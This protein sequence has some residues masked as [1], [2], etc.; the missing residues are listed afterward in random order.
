MNGDFTTP[1]LKDVLL[2]CSNLTIMSFVILTGLKIFVDNMASL[3][4]V[5][6]WAFIMKEGLDVFAQRF[7]R[8]GFRAS[9]ENV[10]DYDASNDFYKVCLLVFERSDVDKLPGF[11][12]QGNAILL[13]YLGRRGKRYHRGF[14][15]TRKTGTSRS[16]TRTEDQ[17]YAETSPIEARRASSGDRERLGECRHCGEPCLNVITTFTDYDLGCKNGMYR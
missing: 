1:D 17:L 5:V 13:S 10:A 15:R 6:T 7:I 3:K 9:V 16:G 14:A 11:S 8:H 2:A 4:G 12:Q